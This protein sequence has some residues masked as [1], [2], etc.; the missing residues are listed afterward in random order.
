MNETAQGLRYRAEQ[1]WLSKGV[2]PCEE[3][4]K[5][6]NEAADRGETSVLWGQDTDLLTDAEI[7]WLN[8]RKF[9]VTE[10]AQRVASM[11]PAQII[12]HTIRW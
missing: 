12:H 10:H 2:K 1:T 6:M 11:L 8:Y 3:L 5:L 4:L 9:E 7:M